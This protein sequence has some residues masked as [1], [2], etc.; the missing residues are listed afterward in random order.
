[1]TSLALGLRGLAHGGDYNPEQWPRATWRDDVALMQ[2]AGV[3]LVSLGV[4]SWAWLEPEPGRYTFDWLDEVMDLLAGGG[5][6]VDLATA[7][8]S[9]PAWM[10]QRHP[11][12][13][14]VTADG[15]VLV[16]GGRQ[17]YCPSSPVFREHAAG[18]VRELATR[19]RDHEALA[20]WHVGNEYACHVTCC[21]CDVSAVAFRAWLAARYG[22]VD[23]LNEAWGTAFWSQRYTD[24]DEV[25]PPRTAPTF[26]NPTQ[27]LDFRRFSS[28][29]HL[30]CFT[31][32]RDL[33]HALTPGV[34]VTTNFMAHSAS[35]DYWAWAR[36]VDVVSNDHYLRAD[37]PDNHIDLAFEADTARG[38]AGGRPWLLME[39]ST[40]A[41]N[42]QPRNVPKLAGQ[43]VRN[44]LQHV[45]RGSDGA[46]FFQWRQSRAGA[47]K[48]HSAMVP[49]AGTDS[50]LWREVV[51]LG[52]TLRR[53]EPVA[54]STVQ[55]QVALVLSWPAE[56]A[57]EGPTQPSDDVS[58]RDRAHALHAALFRQGVTVDVVR[59]DADLSGYRLVLVPTLYLVTDA[60]A[61][62]MAA[63]V[64]SGGHLLVTYF[65]GIVDEHDHVRLGGYPG[66]FRELLGVRVEEF[67]PLLA[68]ETVTLVGDEGR[69]G[70]ADVWI[71][72]LHLAGAES[73]LAC[74]D[75]PRTGTPAV[76]RHAAGSGVAWYVATRT[77]RETT[78]RLLRD[79]CAGAGVT[80]EA[81]APPG[82]E[83]VRR[84][85]AE[86]TYLFVLNHTDAP[87][88]VP[89]DGTDLV[90]GAPVAGTVDL[91]PGGVAVV[92][93]R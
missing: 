10:G 93:G 55:A 28:D 81:A 66:A 31:A 17:A 88:S 40:S 33:L 20:M 36:E 32:E 51:E 22:S 35:V 64:R 4:F 16:H 5:V 11:E 54:G 1:M 50:R 75:G 15:T 13:R 49:H 46:L 2:E 89:A 58:Y 62:S 82:V 78:D 34:P 37:D 14:P 3:N 68:G 57:C 30:G 74:A 21:W 90:T 77:D 48:Y 91:A 83:V 61:E 63:Y 25:L 59:P 19:Y 67:H 79:V 27:R 70:A 56:W 38:L 39:H 71:E 26:G 6:R 12:T 9:P 65:S 60:D 76:T 72:D 7:T 73:V 41:V 18:L 86:S 53:L 29:A 69:T 42:W 92:R 8:A 44:S 80:P 85:D 47:E 45:A 84:R 52:R 24:L 23:A 43:T 87:A